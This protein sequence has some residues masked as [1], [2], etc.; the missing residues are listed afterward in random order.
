MIVQQVA[1]RSAGDQLQLLVR[2]PQ[3]HHMGM[4]PRPGSRQGNMSLRGT[5]KGEVEGTSQ[6]T[7]GQIPGYTGFI[8]KAATNAH[9]NYQANA[10]STRADM[11]D[12]LFASYRRV[13][14]GYVGFQPQS[15][16]NDRS[17]ATADGTTYGAGKAMLIGIVL[18]LSYR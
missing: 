12:T 2:R 7:V 8:P 1:R 10:S 9:A 11:K 18:S 6:G 13:L 4:R 15:V 5:H 17:F 14:P 16:H 3:T